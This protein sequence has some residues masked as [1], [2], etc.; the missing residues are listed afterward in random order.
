[1]EVKAQDISEVRLVVDPISD[2]PTLLYIGTTSSARNPIRVFARRKFEGSLN[3][4]K[5]EFSYRLRD[6]A[7]IVKLI[8]EGGLSED[9]GIICF[10]GDGQAPYEIYAYIPVTDDNWLLLLQCFQNRIKPDFFFQYQGGG[11]DPYKVEKTVDL[12]LEDTP[13]TYHFI[14]NI[15][16]NFI[17]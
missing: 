17:T 9:S 6:T 12:P 16:I 4:L 5:K 15:V 10:Y 2:V 1:M 13:V 3:I 11:V 7:R 14:H 8:D